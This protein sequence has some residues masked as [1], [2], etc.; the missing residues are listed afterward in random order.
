MK[1]L[2]LSLGLLTMLTVVVNAQSN[3]PERNDKPSETCRVAGEVAGAVAGATVGA[4]IGGAGGAATGAATGTVVK[5]VVTNACEAI[6]E[7][8]TK[9][10]SPREAGAIKDGENPP[11]PFGG[12][13]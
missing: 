6:R 10:L 13:Q 8:P 7:D 2:F 5:E 4:A 1:K 9:L 11:V 12:K 3:T